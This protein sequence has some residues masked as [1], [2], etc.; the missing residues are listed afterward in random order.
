VPGSPI[1]R[2]TSWESLLRLAGRALD[3][4]SHTRF[5]LHA[6]VA[7]PAEPTRCYLEVTLEGNRVLGETELIEQLMEIEAIRRSRG[8]DPESEPPADD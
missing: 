1:P 4:T 2:L 7:T 3:L 8:W 6:A 5:E